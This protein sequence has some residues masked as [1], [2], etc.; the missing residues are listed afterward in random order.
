M[1][2]DTESSQREIPPQASFGRRPVLW[3]ATAALSSAVI[4]GLEMAAARL[5]APWFG[6]SAHVWAVLISVVMLALAVGYFLGGR[7]ADRSPSDRPMY[8]AILASGVYQLAA[9][10]GAVGFLESL[11]TMD[12]RSGTALSVV[13]LFATH[14]VALAVV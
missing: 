3:G 14:M 13:L 1:D 2:A 6:A 11:A 7:L 9:L 10:F 4:M 12:V 8:A 5:M